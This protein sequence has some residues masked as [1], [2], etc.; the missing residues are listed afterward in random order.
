MSEC[1]DEREQ[2]GL[3]RHFTAGHIQHESTHREVG[4]VDDL[5]AGQGVRVLCVDLAQRLRAVE[6]ARRATGLE[7][8]AVRAD[9]ERV[10]IC[11]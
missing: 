1:A 5:E 4:A 3:R 7:Q 2:L 8:D 6:E 10:A 11:T 9:G